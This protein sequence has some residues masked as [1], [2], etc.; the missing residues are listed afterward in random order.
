[1][2][3][4]LHHLMWLQTLVTYLL[5]TDD[6]TETMKDR[7]TCGCQS[8]LKVHVK[9]RDLYLRTFLHTQGEC[10]IGH[11]DQISVAF[12]ASRFI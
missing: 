8:H 1:M 11:Y 7:Q 12:R 5:S 2:V 3:G 9:M 6:K 4:P 10:R